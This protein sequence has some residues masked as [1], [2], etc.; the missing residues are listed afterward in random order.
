MLKK[1]ARQK[2]NH[3]GGGY[4]KNYLLTGKRKPIKINWASVKNKTG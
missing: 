2:L 3:S 4:C 1:E